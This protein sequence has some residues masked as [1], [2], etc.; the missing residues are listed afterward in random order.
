MSQLPVTVTYSLEEILKQIN[1][2][3]DTLQKDVSDFK[4]ETKVAIE[5]IKGDIKTF[6]TRFT[7]VENDIKNIKGSQRT[8]ILALI[9]ILGTALL[10]TVARY[11]VFQA[12]EVCK[13]VFVH[14]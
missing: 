10:G 1:Q 9:G 11:S 12:G 13:E 14:R 4:T 3:L 8:K 7:A 2:K 6:D 5:S